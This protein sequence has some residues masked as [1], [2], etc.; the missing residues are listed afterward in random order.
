MACSVLTPTP[1]QA[2]RIEE[3]LI[4]TTLRC[5]KP[6]FLICKQ[7]FSAPDVLIQRPSPIRPNP[8][9]PEQE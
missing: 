9:N 1:P 6:D 2:A 8:D 7:D 5:R 3:S 4:V